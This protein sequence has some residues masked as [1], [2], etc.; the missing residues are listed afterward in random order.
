MS[1]EEYIVSNKT[2]SAITE[3]K[4]TGGSRAYNLLIYNATDEYWFRRT[5]TIGCVSP[6]HAKSLQQEIDKAASIWIGPKGRR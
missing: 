1:K 4:L 3:T 5:I 2:K 6:D